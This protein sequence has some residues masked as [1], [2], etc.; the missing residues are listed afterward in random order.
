[1]MIKHGPLSAL[2]S[3]RFESKN[4]QLKT[5]LKNSFNN[6]NTPFSAAKKEQYHLNYLFFHNSLPNHLDQPGKLY[7]TQQ[8]E[9]TE[10]SSSLGIDPALLRSVKFI[11]TYD[12]VRFNPN[13]MVAFALHNQGLPQFYKIL[14][15][16]VDLQTNETYIKGENYVTHMFSTHFQAY[17]VESLGF[18]SFYKLSDRTYTFP[19]TLVKALDYNTYVLMRNDL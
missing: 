15:M 13:N 2:S 16:Y 18:Y 5:G 6:I 1:M 17:E 19:N 10:V 4:K 9:L 14:N 8:S 7:V 11:T 3:F 12:G